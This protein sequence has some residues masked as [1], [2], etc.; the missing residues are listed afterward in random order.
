VKN[1]LVLAPFAYEFG[2]TDDAKSVMTVLAGTRGY[3]GRV[4]L[5]ENSSAYDLSTDTEIPGEAADNR[6]NTTAFRNW[7]SYEVVHLSTHGAALSW[8][9]SL[10]AQGES[11]TL[12]FLPA[13]V[14]GPPPTEIPGTKAKKT[15]ADGSVLY[16]DGRIL[17]NLESLDCPKEQP[18]C[19]P[20]GPDSQYQLVVTA[21]YF[22]HRYGPMLK[23]RII[24]F[25]ACEMSKNSD[26][27]GQI[28]IGDKATFLAW[29]KT[30]HRTM[31]KLKMTKVFEKA[32]E[33]G[34]TL[35]Q[36]VKVMGKDGGLKDST[37]QAELK[38]YGG[39]LRLREI[40]R[41]LDSAHGKHNLG[42]PRD[43]E[44][45]RQ[46][47][48][49]DGVPDDDEPDKIR[50][51]L[52]VD[53]LILG[54]SQEKEF[55]LEIRIDGD[56]VYSATLEKA[57]EDAEKKAT[58][59][60]P[61]FSNLYRF[62]LVVDADRPISSRQA[63]TLQARVNLPEGG[64]S[65]H[66]VKPRLE[67]AHMLLNGGTS[68]TVGT[69]QP[70]DG[71][72]TSDQVSL[73]PES[74]AQSIDGLASML[75]QMDVQLPEGTSRE[76]LD[77]GLAALS[78]TFSNPEL[79]EW[80]AAMEGALGGSAAAGAM[81]SAAA[82]GE[83][84]EDTVESLPGEWFDGRTEIFAAAVSTSYPWPPG[85]PDVL[86][87]SGTAHGSSTVSVSEGGNELAFT[88][89]LESAPS[90]V[91]GTFPP[92]DG[93]PG[94]R[95]AV[96]GAMA[97]AGLSL[98]AT[99]VVPVLTDSVYRLTISGHSDGFQEASGSEGGLS[100]GGGWMVW[101]EGGIPSPAGAVAGL[102]IEPGEADEMEI[103][104]RVD[105]PPDPEVRRELHLTVT[106]EGRLSVTP[107]P[108][109]VFVPDERQIAVDLPD[110][111][112]RATF[113]FS[114]TVALEPASEKPDAQSS[115]SRPIS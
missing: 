64:Y 54:G 115:A 111:P 76:Q 109:P 24:S 96:A 48:T 72:G 56:L 95:P 10:D 22:T 38:A 8:D 59:T 105:G 114:G 17:F 81:S 30:V 110:G 94:P 20:K 58:G 15:F 46:I 4:E 3:R 60:I 97:D 47:E 9:V 37:H 52:E 32:S 35:H 49:V 104:I 11:D 113:A 26:L 36:I 78:D 13:F 27:L 29:T 7:L 41:L 12:I 28:A 80:M 75:Q 33:T 82:V 98:A 101:D 23:G 63:Y 112:Q 67:G 108:L 21:D 66:T 90:V 86:S 16:G 42:E 39:E 93:I 18:A 1:A 83:T 61:D 73:D 77:Q 88:A 107:W 31:A 6:V 103:M 2:D 25:S 43:L 87:V 55:E 89:T 44:D 62:S 34:L 40:V 91:R 79:G 71:G 102:F 5:L 92:T 106:I 19:G 45:S 65:I 84:S 74:L 50:L 51:W 85:S 14:D 100:L 69:A 68:A 57:L 70:G 99:I 53:G